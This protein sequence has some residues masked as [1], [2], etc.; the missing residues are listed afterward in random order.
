MSTGS[1]LASNHFDHTVLWF[2]DCVGTIFRLA[3]NKPSREKRKAEE[4][5]PTIDSSGD[6]V[7]TGRLGSQNGCW[8]GGKMPRAR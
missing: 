8:V 4:L 1:S 7:T 5:L 3:T 6:T 2:F